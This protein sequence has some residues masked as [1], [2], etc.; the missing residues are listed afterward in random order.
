MNHEQF[1]AMLDKLARRPAWARKSSA[2]S[3]PGYP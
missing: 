1:Q 2:R 3:W